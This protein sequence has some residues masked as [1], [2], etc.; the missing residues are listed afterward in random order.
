MG[1]LR[2]KLKYK[3][4]EIELEGEEATVQAE[5]KDIKQNGLGN[6]VN[7]VDLSEANFI[8]DDTTKQIGGSKNPDVEIIDVIPQSSLPS[9]K[10]VIMKQLPSSE[11]EWI[12]VYAYFASEGG[13][14][15]FTPKN[16][17]EYYESTKRKTASR[18]ANM[19]QNIKAL[20]GKG[21]F[22]A[23]NDDEYILTEDGKH[24]ASEILTRKHSIPTSQTKPTSKS[25]KKETKKGEPKQIKVFRTK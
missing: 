14:K 24:E 2:I 22:S 1:N 9:L 20:F 11:R 13:S 16:I 15:S 19:S 21:Y 18:H 3:S 5:F 17:L 8:I 10:D 12:M 23:L 7:G 4:F 6:V 25:S